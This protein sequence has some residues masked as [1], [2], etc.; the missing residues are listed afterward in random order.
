MSSQGLETR[1]WLPRFLAWQRL[2][3]ATDNFS[4]F[5]GVFEQPVRVFSTDI[6]QAIG[7]LNLGLDLRQ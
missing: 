1:G 6:A 2:Q 5:N 3:Y 7:N 4:N